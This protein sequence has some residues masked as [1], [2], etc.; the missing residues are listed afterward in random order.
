MDVRVG[1]RGG[2]LLETKFKGEYVGEAA[3][4]EHGGAASGSSISGGNAGGGGGHEQTVRGGG[5][6]RCYSDPGS[7]RRRRRTADVIA[8]ATEGASAAVITYEALDRLC[9]DHPLLAMAVFTRMA[10]LAMARWRRALTSVEQGGG[11][12]GGGGSVHHGQTVR[13]GGGGGGHHQA[14][15]TGGSNARLDKQTGAG[16]GAGA[17]GDKRGKTVAQ[18]APKSSSKE[19][20]RK[21][22]MS[23][24]VAAESSGKKR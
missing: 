10:T 11:G 4:L 17:R 3:Y 8:W 7:I 16:A 1:G 24:R 23:K 18:N 9:V 2:L 15:N 19:G 20:L 21:A 5:G 13:G 12:G 22:I 6:A 14:G